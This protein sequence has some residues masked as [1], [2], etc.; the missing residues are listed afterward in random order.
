MGVTKHKARVMGGSSLHGF[1]GCCLIY[2]VSRALPQ[3][4]CWT[5]LLPSVIMAP[6]L[7]GQK[8]GCH[9]SEL[10]SAWSGPGHMCRQELLWVA[11]L[12]F[13]MS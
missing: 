8:L 3:W 9:A 12:L 11:L 1:P 4:H 13:R 7:S 5:S 10:V 2:P 6:S